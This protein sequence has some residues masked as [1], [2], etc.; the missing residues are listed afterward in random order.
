MPGCA[1]IHQR[2]KDVQ[3]DGCV[4]NDRWLHLL[5][6]YQDNKDRSA[7]SLLGYEPKY[8]SS[9][10]RTVF[11]AEEGSQESTESGAQ[12]VEE[13]REEVAQ[14]EARATEQ[15]REVVTRAEARGTERAREETAQAGIQ[16]KRRAASGTE[17]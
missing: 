16:T 7:W 2:K 4:R 1:D 15:A 17:A 3:R 12:V 5:Y 10:K 8:H 14:A 9:K 11:V 6:G 13:V